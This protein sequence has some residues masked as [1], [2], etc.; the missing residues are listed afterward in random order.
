MK[1]SQKGFW[2]KVVEIATV[3]PVLLQRR[4]V[5]RQQRR[6][7][8]TD[9]E[10]KAKRQELNKR[11]SRRVEELQCRSLEVLPDSPATVRAGE[12]GQHLGS[13]RCHRVC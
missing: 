13:G 1:Q 4:R 2:G 7:S 12:R 9:A 8:R 3:F 6:Y 5:K 11:G 10:P